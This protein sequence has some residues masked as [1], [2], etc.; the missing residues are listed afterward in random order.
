MPDWVTG[1]AFVIL[2]A[3]YEV[4]DPHAQAPD[5]LAEGLGV[6]PAKG[7]SAVEAARRLAQ[8]GANAL[9]PAEPVRL[10]AIFLRQFRGAVVALLAAAAVLSVVFGDLPETIA[11]TAVILINAAIGFATEVSAVRSM[12]ALQQLGATTARVRRD[13]AL[14]EVDAVELVP[15]DVVELEAGDVV[16]A[17]L[18]LMDAH[19]LAC[20]ESAL[21]GESAPVSKITQAVPTDTPLAE[22]RSM[23]FKGT[24]ITRGSGAGLV[25]GTGMHTELGAVARLVAEAKDEQTPLEQRLNA[26]GRNLVW[27]VLLIAVLIIVLGVMRGK[28]TWTMV[29]TGIALAVASIP[30]GLPIVATIALSRG[31]LRMVRRKA[32][33]RRLSSV[34]TLGSASVIFTDKTGT[35]TE[36][37]MTVVRF[38]AEAGRAMRESDGHWTVDPGAQDTIA[39]A[40][41]VA[42]LCNNASVSPVEEG[43]WKTV[44][45]PLEGGLMLAAI[46]NGADPFELR[47]DWPEVREEPFDSDSKL[48]A[49]FHTRGEHGA[50]PLLVAVK[51]APEAVLR[52]CT[53]VETP[54]GPR[55][56]TDT[57]RAAWL[58]RNNTIAAD[59]IRMLALAMKESPDHN[60][61]PYEGL[62]F[63][64]LVGMVDPPRADVG[65]SIDACRVAGIRVIMVTGDQA[66]TARYV[67]RAVGIVADEEAPVVLGRDLRAP[68]TLSAAEAE[69]V[70]RVN[71]FARVSPQQKLDLI[72]LHQ[73][74]GQI[75]AMTGDGINDAPALKKADIGVAM[76]QRGTQV[77]RE[78]ADVV[79]K[80][81]AFATIVAAVQE[82]RVIFG[83]IRKFVVY[84]LSCNIAEIL[85]I[86][87]ASLLNTALPVLPLQ[88]LFL[89]VVTDVFPALALGMGQ[90]DPGVMQRHPRPKDEALLPRRHWW[91]IAT[92]GAYLAV[93]TLGAFFIAQEV[94]HLDPVQVVTVSFLTLACGQLA[95][96]FNMRNRG[97]R[98][99]SNDVTRNPHVWGAIVLCLMLLVF[100]VYLPVLQRV[101]STA[102]LRAEAWIVVALFSILPL[103]LDV[104][105]RGIQGMRRRRA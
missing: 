20:D 40:L 6:V 96:V 64:C 87:V 71:I 31:L 56:M 3:M 43:G 86:F 50:D 19:K 4:A 98:F 42:V 22:R 38:D 14:V 72:A 61:P 17:D 30:E 12:E 35:L 21:T 2:P 95:H 80:D 93:G 25:V 63:L 24:S 89:N 66:L 18:R 65:A 81:D 73:R 70:R 76:G 7:L 79:L 54:K 92:Y 103:A 48:M 104:V 36:N 34:E 15:G 16:A 52:V 102:P 39:Q 9:R 57:E 94:L 101:L 11:I 10:W 78:V 69:R 82:G 47:R 74:A 60:A 49:T 51:G 28:D 83:N 77:A 88:I 59:G 75:V 33:V 5:A 46:E 26:L 85:V 62:R 100:A 1:Y 13:G 91:T 84:L 8:V 32:L 37:R 27:I 53:E 99:W 29:Q 90:G 68:D 41:R 105:A 97:A 45:D 55:P 23:A 67:A 44:G 58:E